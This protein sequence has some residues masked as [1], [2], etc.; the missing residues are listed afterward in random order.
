MTTA[1]VP[2]ATPPRT[3]TRGSYVCS[4]CGYGIHAPKPLPPCPMCRATSWRAERRHR[5]HA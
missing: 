4:E 5:S 3:E 2:A 1:P